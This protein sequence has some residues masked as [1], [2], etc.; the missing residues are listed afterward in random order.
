M[1]LGV[2]ILGELIFKE[3]A[4]YVVFPIALI[5]G[6]TARQVVQY[7]LGYTLEQAIEESRN[8]ND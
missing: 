7:F 8:K 5:L 3:N 4:K 2:C 1:V 6:F